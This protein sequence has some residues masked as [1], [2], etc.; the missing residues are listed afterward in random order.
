VPTNL[1]G[2][3]TVVPVYN[4]GPFEVTAKK[5]TVTIGR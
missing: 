1:K 3:F 2:T 4:A 5:T